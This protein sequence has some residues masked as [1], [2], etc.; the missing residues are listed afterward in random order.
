MVRG[1]ELGSGLNEVDLPIAGIELPT[2]NG[3]PSQLL[4]ILLDPLVFD[5]LE[6]DSLRSLMATFLR[7]HLP[8]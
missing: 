8:S 1:L 5:L 2:G 3:H 7:D 6:L 4:S